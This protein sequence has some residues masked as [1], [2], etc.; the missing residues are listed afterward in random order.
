[1]KA[2]RERARAARANI[3][4]WS[5]ASKGIIADF[6]KTEFVGY[7]EDKCEATVIGIVADDMAV[8]EVTEGQFS[9]ITDRTVFYGE[10]GGQVG[11]TGNAADGI[12]KIIIEDTKKTDGVY[13]HI[14]SLPESG[15]IKVGDKVTLEIDTERRAAIRRNHSACHMLQ[16]A[17]RSVLGVHVEQAG[18][19]VDEQRLRFDFSHFSA[20][21]ADELSK[22]ERLVNEEILR[23]LSVDTVETDIETARKEGAM[24][25]FGEKYGAVVRMVKIGDFSTELCGGTH[26]R[27]TGN[28][29]LF[30][31][32]SESSVAAGIRRIEATT[33]FGVLSML[34]DRDQL[35]AKAAAELKC[36]NPADLANR[37][38][39]V[40]QEMKS[41]KSEI[42]A[43]EAKIASMKMS[44]ITANAMKVGSVNVYPAKL[45]GVALDA[46]RTL[47]DDIRSKDQ[48]AVVVIALITDGRLNFICACGKDALASGANAGKIV[49]DIAVICGG[50][51]GGRPDSATAGGKDL[52]KV[53]EALS[54][55]A[56][57][58][59]KYLK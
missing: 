24:A 42:E 43:L 51:G 44:D 1:M 18:S 25:L 12:Y 47:S 3:S 10:G 39:A 34:S 53:D 56:G 32:I 21:T 2:Q 55:A 4:G 49:K 57:T 16:A 27:N 41:A 31:I 22:V 13:V 20:M 40:S 58:V 36:V 35:I 38:A 50:G 9:L 23:S 46:A 8:E 29:G 45:E 11:D 5:D 7:T 15:I 28:I 33:G 30:R 14:C 26:V 19:Y 54:S 59:A 6:A 52:S 48:S 17:L 37:A